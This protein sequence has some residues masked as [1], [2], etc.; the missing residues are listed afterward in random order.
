MSAAIPGDHTAATAARI[1]SAM[2]SSDS[3]DVQYGGIA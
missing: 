1:A 2:R 3:P